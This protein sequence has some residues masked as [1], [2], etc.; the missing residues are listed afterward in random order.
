MPEKKEEEEA[1]EASSCTDLPAPGDGDLLLAFCINDILT[2]D[3]L[4]SILSKLPTQQDKNA[5]GLV[6]KRWM[7]IQNGER[8]RLCVRAGPMMLERLALRFTHLIDLDLTQSASRS[9]FPG[10]SDADLL[11]VSKNFRLLERINLRE[12]KGLYCFHG[13]CAC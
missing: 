3:D 8:R 11:T 5:F 10:V 2:D 13:F 7:N 1:E 6:C 9:F 12:C 4:L